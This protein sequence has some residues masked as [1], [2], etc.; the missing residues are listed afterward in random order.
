MATG[1]HNH[2]WNTVL[3]VEKK[4]D[5]LVIYKECDCGCITKNEKIVTHYDGVK[6]TY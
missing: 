3:L 6:L 4:G 1:E 5:A 2:T